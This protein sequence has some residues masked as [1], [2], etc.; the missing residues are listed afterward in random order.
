MTNEV[1]VQLGDRLRHFINT[2]ERLILVRLPEGPTK[3]RPG[4]RPPAFIR[5]DE[6]WQPLDS[7]P[8]V[9]MG[10]FSYVGFV[11]HGEMPEGINV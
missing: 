3:E 7:E 2:D 1:N 11:E 9:I 8:I 5:A 6:A 10:G 4:G